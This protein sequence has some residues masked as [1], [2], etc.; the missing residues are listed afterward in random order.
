MGSEENQWQDLKKTFLEAGKDVL[1]YREWKRKEHYITDE[2]LDLFDRRREMK[3]N[4]AEY[5]KL[6]EQLQ[7]KG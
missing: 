5:R 4:P 7:T 6:N 2:I 1:G 3:S